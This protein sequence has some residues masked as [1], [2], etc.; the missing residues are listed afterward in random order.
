MICENLKRGI[1]RSGKKEKRRLPSLS[2][3]EIIKRKPK[4][5]LLDKA[6]EIPNLMA[7]HCTQDRYIG[8]AVFID[9][10]EMISFK[11]NVYE[12]Y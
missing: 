2:G 1:I 11:I 10:L 4:K 8:N 7:V 5:I 3:F 12:I 6:Y 9:L